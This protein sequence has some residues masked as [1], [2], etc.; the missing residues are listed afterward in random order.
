MALDKLDQFSLNPK[1]DDFE[2]EIHDELQNISRALKEINLLIDQS[3]I[4]LNKLV[5][6]NQTITAQFQQALYREGEKFPKT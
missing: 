4:E 5:Q 1:P 6:R 3:Q 2:A